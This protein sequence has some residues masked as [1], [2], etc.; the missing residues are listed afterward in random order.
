M[1]ELA[2]D[3]GDSCD[4]AVGFDGAQD[5]AGI[6]IDLEDL[7]V[8]VHAHPECSFSPREPG[9]TAAAGCRDRAQYAAGFGVDLLD[10]ILGDLEEVLP[11]EG[12]PGVG[13][14]IDRALQLA[15]GGIEGMQLVT[16]REPD[17]LAVVA[18]A[19]HFVDARKGTVFADD[20]GVCAFHG[21]ILL[22]R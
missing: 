16:G 18:D 14:D 13:R 3:P 19:M 8:P 12:R 15:A 9:V 4:E 7:P 5:R 20:F 2:V 17:L 11:V 22:T 21:V 10:P 6:G 1:P